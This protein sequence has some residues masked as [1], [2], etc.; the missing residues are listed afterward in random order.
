MMC[1]VVIAASHFAS[2][3]SKWAG[4]TSGLITASLVLGRE[5]A[6]HGGRVTRHDLRRF[7]RVL[8]MLVALVVVIAAQ[9]FFMLKS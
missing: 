4:L 9:R 6:Y 1:A 7:D 8:F 3:L 5:V 2:S